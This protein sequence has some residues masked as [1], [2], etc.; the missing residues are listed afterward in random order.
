MKN[1]VPYFLLAMLLVGKAFA[2]WMLVLGS[3]VLHAEL[4]LIGMFEPIHQ[5]SYLVFSSVLLI[6]ISL[7]S[8]FSLIALA[9]TVPINAAIFFLRETSVYQSIWDPV[10]LGLFVVAIAFRRP[11]RWFSMFGENKAMHA[12]SAS[13]QG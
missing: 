2:W 10:L 11:N 1:S 12:T 5:F 6:G 13:P 9:L 7:G 4:T 3:N 8:R